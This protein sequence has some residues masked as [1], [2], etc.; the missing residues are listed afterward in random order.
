MSDQNENET[1]NSEVVETKSEPEAKPKTMA[2]C[3]VCNKTMRQ[4]SMR[5]HLKSTRHLK[6]AG[7]GDNEA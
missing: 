5:S 6:K 2:T 1:Q 4:S 3:D 7:L